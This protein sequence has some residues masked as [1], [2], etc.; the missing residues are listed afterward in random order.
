MVED[1]LDVVD[2]ESFD[3]SYPVVGWGY[4]DSGTGASSIEHINAH[5]KA[6]IIKN[7]NNIF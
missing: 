6:K 1:V 5:S 2:V 3:S 7:Y 4:S